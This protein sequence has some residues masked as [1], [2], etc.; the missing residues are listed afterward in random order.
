M[1]GLWARGEAMRDWEE[2]RSRLDYRSKAMLT[3]I[4]DKWDKQTGVDIQALLDLVRVQYT[5]NEEMTR[6]LAQAEAALRWCDEFAP[7]IAAQARIAALRDTTQ[8]EECVC[9]SAGWRHC[10]I[11]QDDGGEP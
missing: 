11:H 2:T 1:S 9:D 8:R 6:L 3:S 10:Q 7:G 4:A 5:A